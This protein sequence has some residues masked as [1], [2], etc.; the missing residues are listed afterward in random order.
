MWYVSV[1]GGLVVNVLAF[2]AD[3]ENRR[4]IEPTVRQEL[5][6]PS[7]GS[8]EAALAIAL[9]HPAREARVEE[10]VAAARITAA[11]HAVDV[12]REARP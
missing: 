11:G 9:G 7:R 12:T 1:N 5:D 4:A 8:V 10:L 2:A 3:F 6:H